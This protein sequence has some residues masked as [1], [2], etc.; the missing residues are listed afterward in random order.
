MATISALGSASLQAP[1]NIL[2]RE[3]ASLEASGALER[4]PSARH[5]LK[6]ASTSTG[7]L[8]IASHTGPCKS[9][10][11][12]P[13]TDVAASQLVDSART[14]DPALTHDGGNETPMAFNLIDDHRG[15][16][17]AEADRGSGGDRPAWAD[18]PRPL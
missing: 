4:D 8:T 17:V 5:V 16:E 14:R 13:N 18:R 2:L 6:S 11:M 1:L 7:G 10:G 12:H 3:I 9:P 15:G